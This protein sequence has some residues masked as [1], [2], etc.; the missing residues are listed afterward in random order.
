[1]VTVGAGWI[2]LETTAAAREAGCEVT[3]VEPEPTAL[4]RALGP[5]LG[6]VFVGL[7]REHGVE[8]R[9]GESVS[10]LRGPGGRVGEVITSSGAALPAG[11][12]VV[13]IGA[14]PNT[15]LAAG[16]GLE[17]DNG[18]VADAALH[19]SGPDIYA[20]GDLANSYHPLLGRRVRVE[21]W[22]NA[23]NSGPAAAR[24]MLGQDV[25]YDPVPYFYSDQYDLGMETAGLPEPGT[26]D[27]VLYRG[28]RPGREFVAF[29]LREGA[30]V[31]GMNVNVWD[32]SDDIQALIRSRRKVDPARLT[33][34]DIPI[35]EV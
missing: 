9:F 12:V 22:A 5:E 26:Y 29:W 32:V 7:H 34:P 15:G 21:H 17:I 10:E 4:Y 24:S 6:E 2:G 3:V 13:G 23:L 30:V 27:E 1:V 25:A 16:A 19:T 35:A 11:I 31:A 14:V 20:A 18:V 28:D 8:F 33:D